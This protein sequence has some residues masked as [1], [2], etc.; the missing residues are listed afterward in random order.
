MVDIERTPEGETPA[1]KAS[2][3]AEVVSGCLLAAIL[4]RGR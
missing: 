2:T 1:E 3:L 4:R